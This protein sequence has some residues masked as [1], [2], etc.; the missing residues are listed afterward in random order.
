M[1]ESLL[2]RRLIIGP[3]FCALA[4]FT[5]IGVA[6]E[7]A[8]TG[9]VAPGLFAGALSSLVIAWLF[10]RSDRRKARR[11]SPAKV[12]TG[13]VLAGTGGSAWVAAPGGVVLVLLVL[14]LGFFLGVTLSAAY[15]LWRG[16][17]AE[18]PA[19]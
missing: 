16:T 3:L 15:E 14:G 18:E 13:V 10:I 19:N 12:G 2:K 1:S 11:L 9:M 8:L 4:V 7:A 6:E 17:Y 5:A